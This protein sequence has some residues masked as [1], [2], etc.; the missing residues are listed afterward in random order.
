MD[1]GF[2][3]TPMS[4][5]AY[6]TS[7]EPLCPVAIK[8]HQTSVNAPAHEIWGVVTCAVCQEEFNI[9]F[10]RI[11][12]SRISAGECAKRLEALLNEDHKQ[13]KPH[14]DSYKIPD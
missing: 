14:A 4:Y 8:L 2:R 13:G 11:Y 7:I 10:N 1:L 5:K 3:A 6:D 12:G 9:G